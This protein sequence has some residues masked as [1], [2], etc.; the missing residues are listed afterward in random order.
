[1]RLLSYLRFEKRG[2]QLA[3]NPDTQHPFPRVPPANTPR[4]A[5]HLFYRPGWKRCVLH[6]AMSPPLYPTPTAPLQATGTRRP[7]P[8]PG[9][10]HGAIIG[11]VRLLQQHR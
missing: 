7:L 6:F 1:M 4:K 9:S 11:A 5:V 2:H 3:E 8:F 10:L